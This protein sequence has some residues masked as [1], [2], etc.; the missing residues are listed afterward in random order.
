VLAAAVLTRAT[1]APRGQDGSGGVRELG[2]NSPGVL[3]L[4]KEG[5]LEADSI[6]RTRERNRAR[7]GEEEG[8]PDGWTRG[9]SDTQRRQAAHARANWASGLLGSRCSA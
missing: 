3:Q 7:R 6:G 1:V 9:V 8:G 5:D 2:I 4:R